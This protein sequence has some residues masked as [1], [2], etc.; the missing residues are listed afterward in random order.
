MLTISNWI[1][2]LPAGPGVILS[3]SANNVTGPFAVQ[4]QFSTAITGLTANQFEVVNGLVTAMS[5]SGANY[6]LTVSPLSLGGV[7]VRLPAGQVQDALGETNYDSNVLAVNYSTTDPTLITWLRFDDGGGNLAADSSPSGNSGTL[8][9][10]NSGAWVNGLFGGAL[11][12]NGVNNYVSITNVAGGDFTLSCWI[13]STQAFPV[14]NNT[15]G[16]TGILWSDV[17]G[18]ANDFI[19]GGIYEAAGALIACHFSPA[20]LIFPSMVLPEI[21][22]GQWVHLAATR[23]S[24][25]GGLSVFVNGKLEARRH[26]GARIF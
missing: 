1:N 21:C 2:S 15:F 23:N 12:F 6:N 11:S 26:R 14:S 19:L 22:T 17:G 9:N 13:K 20:I 18:T 4:V 25:T 8:F 10:M 24:I 5:G 7:T 16:G 3:A